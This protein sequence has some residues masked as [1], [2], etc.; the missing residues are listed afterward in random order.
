MKRHLL[1]AWLLTACLAAQA[2]TTYY[3]DASRPDNSGAGTSW[4]AAKRDLQVAINGA[5]S[6]DQV[7]IKAGTY[8]PTHDA[9]GSTTPANNRDKT[10]T[11][12]NGVKVYGGFAGTETQLTQRNWQSNSTVLSGDLGTVNVLTDNAYHVVVSVNLT[13]ATAL[14]GV[15]I[16]KG[17]ATAP[18]GSSVIIGGRTLDRYKGG[19]L[20]NS[21][22]STTFAN[23]SVKTNSADCT[24]TDDDAWGAGVVNENCSSAFSNCL[25]DGN[26]F[27][28]GGSSFGVFGSGMLISTGSCSL[29]RC[30][31][32]NNTSG[33]GFLDASRGGALYINAGTSTITNCVFYNNSAQNGAAIAAG[34]AGANLSVITNCTFAGNTSSYAGT[35]YSGFSKATFKNCIF[36]D[37]NPTI[38][39]VAGRNEIYSQETNTANQ[40]TFINCIV[41]EAA[42]TPLAVTN[43]TMS[44]CLNSNPLLNNLA[45]GDG[46]DNIWMTADG[47]L[48]LQC[49]SPAVNAGTGTSP[50]TDILNLPRIGT[51]DIGAYEG[52]HSAG[53]LNSLPANA[54]LVQLAQNTSG[55]THYS[56]CSSELLAVQS[57][58]SYTLGGTVTARVWVAATQPPTY[59]KR[60]YEITPQTNAQSAT[61]RV[62]LYFSQQE[63]NDFN[64]VNSILLP[65]SASDV[66]GIA[67]IKIEKRAG[68]SSDST[69][70]PDSYTGTVQTLSGAALTTVWNSTAARWEISFDVTGFSGFF[71]KTQS[72]VLP[73]R[74]ISFT[75]KAA[76]DCNQ[77]QWAT[78]AEVNTLSFDVERSTD[79]RSFAPIGSLPAAGSGNN[80][81]RY[82]DYTISTGKVYYRLKMKDTDGQFKHSTVVQLDRTAAA[83]LTVYPNPAGTYLMV[84]TGSDL[85]HST[86]TVRD[87]GGRQVLRTV[88]DKQPCKLDI[89]NLPAGQYYLQVGDGT[90]VPFVKQ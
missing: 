87:L 24:N 23:C 61:A 12:K 73:L 75:G 27:L 40:P 43:T 63:F 80:Q 8:L 67:N 56:N 4:A 34:G 64:A 55:T 31:F 81:Y 30:I 47:G 42:G 86:V 65:T 54:T 89:S 52:N 48:R 79:G 13:A 19:G 77:L 6:G 84:T 15:T 44:G 68:S 21:Y 35:A 26:S 85:Q 71:L 50:A 22:S 82:S 36:W 69:G 7:W 32:A 14:D 46:A 51:P 9:F 29:D 2:Q 83:E 1:S 18:G 3:V 90:A 41:R 49:S 25:F 72:A 70:L 16:T 39:Q 28:N 17:Y 66:A 88:M 59:V 57:G 78:A 10:F 45:D 62:T 11:L 76:G 5:S 74:L 38:S 33:S 20:Y 60:H 58:G 53:A 37:N